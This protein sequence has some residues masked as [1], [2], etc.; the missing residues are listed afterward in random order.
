MD[1]KNLERDIGKIIQKLENQD[2]WLININ[3]TISGN[4]QEGLI[5]QFNQWK[6]TIKIMLWIIGISIPLVTSIFIVI[7]R[8][9]F[10][11]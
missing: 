3:R 9:I 7:L 2:K 11:G 10:K 1:M 5:A 4:G 6:G 8:H